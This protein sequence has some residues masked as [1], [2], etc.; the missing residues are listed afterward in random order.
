MHIREMEERTGLSRANIRY[1]E[2]MGLLHPPRQAN[3]Y[4]DYG[5][6]ELDALLRIRLLHLWGRTPGKWL[7]GL[8]VETGWGRRHEC[9]PAAERVRALGGRR[10]Q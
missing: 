3:G 6:A 10:E 5:P 9:P 1:Y 7:L 8:F 4:R 2:E